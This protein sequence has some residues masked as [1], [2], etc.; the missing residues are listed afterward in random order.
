MSINLVFTKFNDFRLVGVLAEGDHSQGV[1]AV[2]IQHADELVERHH[3][4][5]PPSRELP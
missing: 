1:L 4:L 5:H 3:T 2:L